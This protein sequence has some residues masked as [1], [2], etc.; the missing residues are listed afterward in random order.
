MAVTVLSSDATMATAYS[1]ARSAMGTMIVVITVMN[2]TAAR[3]ILF[4]FHNYFVFYLH[5]YH[6]ATENVAI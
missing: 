5:Y 4:I 3:V 1:R 6:N 2:T